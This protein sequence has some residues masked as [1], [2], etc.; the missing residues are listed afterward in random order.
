MITT[1][2][3]GLVCTYTFHCLRGWAVVS[4]TDSWKNRKEGLGDAAAALTSQNHM[5]NYFRKAKEHDVQ[6]QLNRT[7]VSLVLQV[8]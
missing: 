7:T 4:E 3:N 6:W 5:T 1:Q 2:L 8:V